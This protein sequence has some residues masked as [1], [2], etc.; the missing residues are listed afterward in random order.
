MNTS[1][2]I[3]INTGILHGQLFVQLILGLVITRLVLMVLG[4]FDY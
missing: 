4:E 2:R 3:I 1:R